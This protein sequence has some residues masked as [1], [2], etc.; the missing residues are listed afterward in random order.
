MQTTAI[1]KVSAVQPAQEETLPFALDWTLMQLGF[2]AS[3]SNGTC[4]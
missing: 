1:G 2:N 3:T 4:C